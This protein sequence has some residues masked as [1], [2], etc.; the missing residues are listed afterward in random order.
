[1]RAIVF[2]LVFANL[3]FFVW[4]QGY[5]GSSASPDAIR[6][7]QQLL[8]DQISVVARGEAPALVKAESAGKPVDNACLEWVD[9]N[10]ADADQVERLAAEKFSV[11]KLTRRVVPGSSTYWVFIAPSTNKAAADKKT[12]E[13]KKLGVPEFFVVTDAGPNQYAI[14]LG[15]FSSEEAANERLEILRVKGVKSARVGER[16]VKPDLAAIVATG[17]G[18]KVDALREAVVTL[19]PESK[20]GVCKIPAQ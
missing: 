1:M 13:L 15:I 2:L 18:A 3:L 17:P 8:A 20:P 19:L 11:F 6:L 10:V 5:L 12:T 4:T 7:Q 16:I 14:S 9:L